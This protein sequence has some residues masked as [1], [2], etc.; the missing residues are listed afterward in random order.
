MPSLSAVSRFDFTLHHADAPSCKCCGASTSP[1]GAADFN[2]T[3]E[4]HKAP[5]FARAEIP[6]PY[7]RCSACGFVFSVAFDHFTPQDFQRVIYNDS[8]VLADPDFVERRPRHNAAMLTQDVLDGH[9]EVSVLDYG[10]GNGLLATTLCA[11][12]VRRAKTYDP[13]YAGSMRPSRTFDLVT[14]FEV[15]EHSPTPYETLK[16]MRWF[17]SDRGMMMFSTLLQPPDID[18][19][20]PGWWYASPR[21]GHISLFSHAALSALLTRLGL[22]LGSSNG[23][24]HTAFRRKP[25]EFAKHLFAV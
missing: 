24:L 4:D 12:G 22:T 21:N 13:F 6:V 19:L 14:A 10:G 25:P 8:Y 15:L 23:L 2:R 17:M 11:L 9:R 16:E 7:H 3:C 5:V 18:T 1:F 20:G